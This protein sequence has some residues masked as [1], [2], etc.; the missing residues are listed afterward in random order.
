MRH[1]QPFRPL[2][3]LL[4]L[5]LPLIATAGCGAGPTA[6]GLVIQDPNPADPTRPH[7]F[8]L[9]V[10]E[11]G[12]R[13]EV[14][15][16]LVN[17]DP[18]PLRIK[19]ADGACAC[20]TPKRIR[21]VDGADQVLVE[22][23]MRF[24]DGYILEVP[25]GGRV[26]LVVGVNTKS[27]LPNQEKLAVLRLTTDSVHSPF[28]TFEFHLASKRPFLITPPSIQLG[29]IPQG[30]GGSGRCEIMTAKPGT[31]ERIIDVLEATGGLEA[32]LE[33]LFI[34]G[35]H[36]WTLTATVPPL[37]DQGPLKEKVVLRTV[38]D[39]GNDDRLELDVWAQVVDDVG[40]DT[41]NP[42]L[43]LVGGEAGSLTLELV[44]RVPGMRVRMTSALLTGPAAEHISATFRP[45]E[46]TY[47]DDD[48]SCQRWTIDLT[49]DGALPPGT[50]EGELVVQ[51][52]DRQWP[53]VRTKVRG[54]VR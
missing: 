7:F 10:L 19:R 31:E 38:D 28:M 52:T 5:G 46:G 39:G 6:A 13:L 23:D 25:P 24:R 44:A 35:E 27:M 32:G 12:T 41:P 33:Y 3:A 40:F 21:L 48:G 15:I 37:H 9:G 20:T 16:L 34:N 45:K 43:N 47:L 14:P 42:F 29:R 54:F 17:T 2:L 4:L 8:N 50:F 36:V 26:Q 11:H 51:L 22:G 53:E 49:T 1:R 30:Y 18:D